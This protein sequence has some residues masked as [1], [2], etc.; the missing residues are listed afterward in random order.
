MLQNL[1]SN[2]KAIFFVVVFFHALIHLLGFVKA[3]NLAS[4]NHLSQSISKANGILWFVSTLLF[5]S[6]A[7]LLYLKNDAWWMLSLIAILVSQYL[8]ITSWNDAKFG[9]IA[10]TIILMAMIIGIGVWNFGRIYN[11]EVIQAQKRN[12]VIAGE[13]LT[14]TDIEHL[15][16]PI[17]KYLHY[18]G[19]VGKS[20]VKNFGAE[21]SGKFR[22]S[23]KS[24]WMPFTTVQHNFMTAP[25]RLFF[26]KATMKHMPITG[27]HCFKNG[28]ASMDIRLLSLYKIQYQAGKE[29]NRSET[30]TFFNDM[31]VMA[32]ATL[33]DE[34]IKWVHVSG[35][36]VEAQFTNSGI[37]IAAHLYF[38][39]SGELINFVSNN[40]FALRE[41]GKMVNAPWSTPLREY[42]VIGGYKLATYAETIYSFPEG[43]FC[44]G[45]F[46]LLGVVYNDHDL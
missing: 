30:V 36:T 46:N 28:L 10:N 34:R 4:V 42:R 24:D 26:M 29:M 35:D 12:R 40:R 23:E 43:D 13:L 32:P 6:S 33:I 18:T 5:L 11:N 7:I 8:I 38:N 31:C 44:Y 9:T 16:D 45:K 3:F 15:P 1:N 2:M 21:F 14:E 39:T 27:F 25:T 22:Q 17:K 37:T 20:K 19:S 41:N